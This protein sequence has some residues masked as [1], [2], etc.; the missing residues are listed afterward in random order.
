MPTYLCFSIRFLQ[1]MCHARGDGN[2]PE[3]PPSPLRLFQSLVAAAAARWNEPT[4]LEHA[5]PALRWLEQQPPPMIVAARGEPATT[6][7][8]MYVPNNVG[9]KVAGSWF[10]GEALSL[11]GNRTE[12]DVCPAH[13][14]DA[15]SAVHYVWPV[16]ESGL[17]PH[18]AV[19]LAAARSITRLGWGVDMV[20]AHASILSS[21][22]ES[23]LAGERWQPTDESASTLLRLPAGG[24]LNALIAKHRSFLNRLNRD[25][26]APV[27]PLTTFRVQGYQPTTKPSRRPFI[28]FSLLQT[29]ASGFRPFDP[30]RK[31]MVVAGMLRHASSANHVA[32]ALGWS[33]ERVA[34]FVLGHGEPAGQSHVPVEGPRL[35][36]LPLPS[37]EPRDR[38][39]GRT[40]VVTSIRRTLIT[41][42]GGHDRGRLQSLGRVLS[43]SDLVAEGSSTSVALLARIPDSDKT[44]AR[45]TRA[46][47]TWA[48]VT[49]IILPGYDDP[50]QVRRRLFPNAETEGDGLSL[51]AVERR[52]GLAKLDQRIDHLIRKAIRQA[53][54]SEELARCA[55]FTWRTTGFWPGTEPASRYAFPSKLRRYRRLHVRLTWRD[56]SGNPLNVPGP[57]CL[58][59]GRFSGLGL[60]APV[61]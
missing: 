5:A 13:L 41:V 36:Y 2:E 37:I 49:P 12:K 59:G 32:N 31:G 61:D 26:F 27:P 10:R 23:R 60:F 44:V 1:P 28:A 16:S 15:D 58:G 39:Q 22:E 47:T 38:G 51:S 7:Y 29:D 25:S 30:V 24:T 3:W 43:G 11:A 57:L 6:K 45:Y 56:T 42:F 54:Y 21:V 9:D 50:R 40:E 35:A 53:G 18:Q 17:A 19:L 46:A 34:R 48:T 20:V 14:R 4:E 8:R 33:P 52:T 55:E